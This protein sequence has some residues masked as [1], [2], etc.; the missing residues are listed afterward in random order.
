ML[1]EPDVTRR[2]WMTTLRSTW[3][4]GSCISW[5]ASG[6]TIED[7]EQIVLESEP[8]RRL[9]YTWHTFTPEI[10]QLHGFSD[11]LLTT[12]AE[13]PRSRVLFRFEPVGEEVRLT[14]THD[15]FEPGST[16]A[17]M[18]SQGWPQLLSSPKSLFATGEALPTATV[19]SRE[20]RRPASKD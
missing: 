19:E 16:V 13:E 10:A 12:I 1:T 17:R 2:W 3:T 6:V 8:F 11:D 20:A 14:V 7:P 15:G 18:I 4:V 9:A 5:Q